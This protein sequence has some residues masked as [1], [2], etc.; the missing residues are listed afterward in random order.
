MSDYPEKIWMNIDYEDGGLMD[1]SS[2]QLSPAASE[3]IR[4][5]LVTQWQPIETA[6]HDTDVLL[7]SPSEWTNTG[8][9]IEVGKASWGRRYD[10]GA[11][12]LSWHGRAT[13]WMPIPKVPE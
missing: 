13:H 10:S 3:Y 1:W 8:W 12:S 4:A 7:A 11:S 5:D 9:I 6:P 2:R